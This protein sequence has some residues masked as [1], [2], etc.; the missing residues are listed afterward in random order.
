MSF[1]FPC[2]YST[3]WILVGG[4]KGCSLAGSAC[5]ASLLSAARRSSLLPTRQWYT[6]YTAEQ[7]KLAP[8][9]TLKAAAVLPNWS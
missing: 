3:S 8:P 4:R 6:P 1:L 5:S 7:T 2:S 9:N